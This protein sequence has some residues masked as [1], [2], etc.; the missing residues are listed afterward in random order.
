MANNASRCN[1]MKKLSNEMVDSRLDGRNI[2]RLDDVV[3]ISTSIRWKCTTCD[4]VWDNIPDRVIGKK[5]I[6]CPQCNHT[7]KA[8]NH[9]V[10]KKLPPEIKRIG[11]VTQVHA[12]IQWGCNVCGHQWA[13]TPANIIYKGSG[14]IVCNNNILTNDRVDYRLKGRPI[15]RIDSVVD[16]HTK[17]RWL[18]GKCNTEWKAEPGSVINSGSGC[19]KCVNIASVGETQWL[20]YCGVPQDS[21]HRQVFINI[22]GKRFRV[23]GYIPETNTIYEYWGDFWHGNP[24]IH[25]PNTINARSK[26]T[27]GELYGKTIEKKQ[28][29]TDAGYNLIDIWESDWNMLS[30]PLR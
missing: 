22:E 23:D 3:N 21:T 8:T 6:G 25:S 19:P 26:K 16:T 5:Q 14:C 20:N 7:I 10:D 15:T 9:T 12:K 18:C 24:A 2:I 13:A 17:I 11:N 28:V 29:I 4:Y 27:F 1:Y 30:R